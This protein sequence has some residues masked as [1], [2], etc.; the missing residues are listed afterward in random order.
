M[1]S[2]RYGGMVHKHMESKDM[3]PK[4]YNT[5]NVVMEIPYVDQK[6]IEFYHVMEYL[7]PPSNV[8]AGWMSLFDIEKRHR[9]VALDAKKNIMT[10]LHEITDVLGHS[11]CHGSAKP[12]GSRVG[13]AQVRVKVGYFRP[14][15]YPDPHHGLAVTH[16][17]TR[18]DT[19]KYNINITKIFSLLINK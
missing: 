9:H 11:D 10:A 12:A 19:I 17:K 18:S 15:P 7:P 14:A 1:A 16:E 13:S 8:S 2:E 4:Y 5:C 6:P 3:A